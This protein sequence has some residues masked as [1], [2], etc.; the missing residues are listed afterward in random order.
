M[1]GFNVNSNNVLLKLYIIIKHGFYLQ[2]TLG[3]FQRVKYTAF[4]HDEG[5][6]ITGNV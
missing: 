6:E 1:T 5:V 2:I 4:D 3:M